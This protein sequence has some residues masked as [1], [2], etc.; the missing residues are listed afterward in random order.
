MSKPRSQ[1]VPA[2]D[3][4]MDTERKERS[5]VFFFPKRNPPAS[6]RADSR[7]EAEQL[8]EASNP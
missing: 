8:L 6:V 5:Q 3:R 2:A 7:E 4:S 1:K